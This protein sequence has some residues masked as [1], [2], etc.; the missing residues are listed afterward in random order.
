MKNLQNISS[1]LIA[2]LL[3]LSAA[4]A[5]VANSEIPDQLPVSVAVARCQYTP[6]DEACLSLRESSA[7]SSEKNP[8]GTLA[9]MPRQIPGPPR[10]PRRPPGP[11]PRMGYTRMA[12]PAPNVGHA[13]IGFLI[14][15]TLGVV[16]SNDRTAGSHVA[17][18][19]LC[20]GLG[21]VFGAAVPS[22]SS[23]HRYPPWP[24]DDDDEMA[25]RSK[26]AKPASPEPVPAEAATASTAPTTSAGSE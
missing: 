9:Q 6:A 8:D 5:Q 7:L 13:A 1:L 20:G 14:G 10:L 12:V 16:P 25:S 26:V 15:F 19:L 17:L 18:G 11:Y 4:L 3:L 2:P 22:F 24:D 23:H 21:A